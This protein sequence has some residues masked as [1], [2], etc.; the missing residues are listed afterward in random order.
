MGLSRG[1]GRYWKSAIV[2]AVVAI[3]TPTV[4]EDRLLSEVVDF[5]GQVLA[6]ETGAPG[7][8]IG[9][10]R[11]GETAVF[12]FG[13][14]SDGSGIPPDGN[15]LMRV[16]SITK[17]FTGAVLASLVAD[18]TVSLTDPV[19]QYFHEDTQFPA[20]GERPIRLIDL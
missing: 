11:G 20:M 1:M 16:G 19:G 2:T 6:L 13:E 14:I 15:T 4:A 18:G 12:G 5:T 3:S 8:I 9:A 7:L 10:T 17:V